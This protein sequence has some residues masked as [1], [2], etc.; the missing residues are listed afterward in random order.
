M[1]VWHYAQLRVTY[2][3]RVTANGGKWTIT[4]REPDVTTQR[5]VS[6]YDSAVAELNRAGT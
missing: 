2:D 1:T 3:N 4:W 6:A 5:T